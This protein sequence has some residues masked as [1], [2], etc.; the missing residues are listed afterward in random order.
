MG[1]GGTY[2][3]GGALMGLM[4]T[5]GAEGALMGLRVHLWG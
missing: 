4:E 3:A 2:G 5:F 1:L